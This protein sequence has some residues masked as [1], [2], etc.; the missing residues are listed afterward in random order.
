MPDPTTTNLLGIP[1]Y[2]FLWVVTLVALALFGWRAYRVG[3]VLARGR[4]EPRWDR[5]PRRLWNV[6]VNV[7]GQRRMFHNPGIGL[8]HLVIFWAF[9]FYAVSFAWNLVRG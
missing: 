2:A 8:A 1:G 9:L 4:T 3:A 6:A 5:L 7:G